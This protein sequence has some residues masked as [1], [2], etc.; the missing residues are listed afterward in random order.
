MCVQ[1]KDYFRVTFVPIGSNTEDV[2][3]AIRQLQQ[4]Q[5]RCLAFKVIYHHP[6]NFDKTGILYYIRPRNDPEDEHDVNGFFCRYLDHG[7][8]TLDHMS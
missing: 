1:A 7:D 8:D 4:Y 6:N 5:Q 2:G 3:I